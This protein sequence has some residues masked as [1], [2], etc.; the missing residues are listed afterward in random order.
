MDTNEPMP[1]LLAEAPPEG[2]VGAVDHTATDRIVLALMNRARAQSGLHAYKPHPSL[3]QA[4][5]AHAAWMA[6]NERMDHYG[7]GRTTWADRCRAAGYPGANLSTIGE[8]VA[9]W[10]TSPEQA[11]GDWMGSSGH[12][13]AILHPQFVHAATA[14]ATGRSGRSYWCTNFGFGA[15]DVAEPVQDPHFFFHRHQDA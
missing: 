10:Q 11:F 2:V 3:A 12:R 4:A 8:N 5:Q 15:P 1:G 9:G 14:S 6:A 13:R 7:P